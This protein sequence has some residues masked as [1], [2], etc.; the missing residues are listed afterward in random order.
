MFVTSLHYILLLNL[1]MNSSIA[2]SA[3]GK[4]GMLARSTTSKLKANWKKSFILCL[5]HEKYFSK[6]IALLVTGSWI[7]VLPLTVKTAMR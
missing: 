5:V 6:D 2:V 1:N 4:E 3:L 7:M